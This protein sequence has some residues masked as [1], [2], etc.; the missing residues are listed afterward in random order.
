MSTKP[1]YMPDAA[2]GIKPKVKER[3]VHAR[4]G[5]IL[6]VISPNGT[7]YG[8]ASV[9]PMNP[10]GTFGRS[11]DIK[12]TSL[13]RSAT[14]P[15]GLRR[16]TGYV[17]ESAM[18][19]ASPMNLRDDDA[20]IEAL[21]TDELIAYLDLLDTEAKALDK[22]LTETKAEV[23]RRIRT[24]GTAIVDGIALVTNRHLKFDARRAK[25]LLSDDQLAAISVPKPDAARARILLT[26][27]ELNSV[28]V[29]QEWTITVREATDKDF[30]NA[31]TGHNPFTGQTA[32]DGNVVDIANFAA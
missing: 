20:D 7:E 4:S 25:A 18:E 8:T 27:D 5:R 3:Y 31:T 13:H 23:R 21:G 28:M 16:T 14:T 29:E 15:A 30:E 12:R 11:R 10:D 26:E 22:K 24:S 9:A 19:G 2:R 17:L 1:S 6:V 32:A